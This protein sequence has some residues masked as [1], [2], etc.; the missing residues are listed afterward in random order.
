[1]NQA[2]CTNCGAGLNI[3]QGDKTCVCSFCQTTNIV[4]NALALGKVEIDVTKDIKKLRDNLTT[5]VQ[6]NSIDEILRVSQ[7]L[8]DWIPQD[9][10]ALYFFAYAKQQQNQPKFIY[11]FLEN[12][13]AHTKEEWET[14]KHHV[15]EHSELRDKK[16]VI[17]F[18]EQFDTSSIETFIG[19]HNNRQKA[20]EYYANVPRDVFICFSTW[21]EDIAHEVLETIERDGYTCWISTRNL[22]PNDTDN[23]W[24]NIENAIEKANL[25]IVISSEEAMR[26]KD[27][28]KEVELAVNHKKIRIEYKLDA[29]NPTSLFKYAFDG[30]K[31][32]NFDSKH[33][34]L[35]ERIF[36]VLKGKNSIKS[37]PYNGDNTYFN[38]VEKSNLLKTNKVKFFVLLGITLIG[39][40][41]YS[42]IIQPIH[43]NQEPV[44]SGQTSEEEV[45]VSIEPNSDIIVIGNSGITIDEEQNKGFDE[46]EL[47][48]RPIISLSSEVKYLQN[49]GSSNYLIASGYPF[50]LPTLLVETEDVNPL[51][52]YV[53]NAEVD[54]IL[55]YDLPSF[56]NEGELSIFVRDSFNQQSNTI[57]LDYRIIDQFSI[58]KFTYVDDIPVLHTDIIKIKSVDTGY[59]IA[60]N[61]DERSP[62]AIDFDLDGSSTNKFSS[63]IKISNDFAVEWVIHYPANEFQIKD[64]IAMNNE[65]FVLIGHEF[66]D[67]FCNVK[68]SNGNVAVAKLISKEGMELNTAKTQSVGC[69]SSFFAGIE[70]ENKLMLLS[71]IVVDDERFMYPVI[72]TELFS[73]NLENGITSSHLGQQNQDYYNAYRTIGRNSVANGAVKIDW[74]SSP[75][76]NDAFFTIDNQLFQIGQD[77]KVEKVYYLRQEPVRPHHMTIQDDVFSV[78]KA[79]DNVCST[80]YL[81]NN[82]YDAISINRNHLIFTMNTILISNNGAIDNCFTSLLDSLSNGDIELGSEIF[83]LDNQV[84]NNRNI[85]NSVYI[86]SE[87]I[88]KIVPAPRSSSFDVS[89]YRIYSGKGIYTI[90][91]NLN[92]LDVFMPY[93]QFGGRISQIYDHYA[94][95]ADR[96]SLGFHVYTFEEINEQDR[97]IIDSYPVIL[98]THWELT[99]LSRYEAKQ[100]VNNLLN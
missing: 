11:T 63:F 7:K 81:Q 93:S 44:L 38:K 27:V 29:S 50:I 47:I 30:I 41:G 85:I 53:N 80:Y 39:M 67:R 70:I 60:A 10:V 58:D 98:D 40:L 76:I 64:I 23:Y 90:D 61:L 46:N 21:N 26:S 83:F 43:N 49:E 62:F 32:V 74:T 69:Q 79:R 15:F 78:I 73:L 68:V 57:K 4:E 94:N 97:Y 86:P 24:S 54:Q 77:A 42:F 13:T 45:D 87:K 18:L 84:F 36:Q 99:I 95:N 55:Y 52:Y 92:L 100:V 75:L 22:R 96:T 3:T 25:F 48:N 28:Q 9:F 51:R 31:W 66:G 6:Q 16:R 56:P 5:F 33:K 82:F 65:N 34:T 88:Y 2:K 1:M 20:E 17:Q 72:N 37:E 14:I 12:P 89:M 71:D 59:L 35:L 91:E 8:L 19:V